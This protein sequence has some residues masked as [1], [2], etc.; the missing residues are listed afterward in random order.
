MRILE[1]L[2][3][4]PFAIV[5]HR[6]AGG[7]ALENTL[8]AVEQ[9]IRSGADIVEVDVRLTRDGRVVVFHDEDLSRITGVNV[10]INSV[11]YEWLRQNARLPNGEPIPLLSEVLEVV[12]DRAGLFIEL[13]EVDTAGGSIEAVLSHG[14]AEDVAFIS[15]LDEAIRI[16]KELN[17]SLVTGLIYYKPPGR[18]I[19][20]LKLK[21]SIVLPR[22]N[23]ATEKAIQ[24]AKRHG[25]KTV[26]WVVND[27]EIALRL[28]RSG[29]DGLASDYP[30]RLSS[31]RSRLL[32]E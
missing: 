7:L 26:V 17:P 11:D 28:V 5:G 25:L 21:A 13:K 4:K 22:Y 16:V 23:I 32:S 8:Q 9:G 14:L 20:A 1:R 27:E 6:G 24:L 3:V 29:V 10:R 30:D 18:V 2:S 31:L 12:K 15:F 19:D